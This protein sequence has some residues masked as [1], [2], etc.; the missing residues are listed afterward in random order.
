MNSTSA[1]DQSRLRVLAACEQ[2]SCVKQISERV[3]L[4]KAAVGACLKKLDGYVIKNAKVY[5][6]Q[7]KK[8]PKRTYVPRPINLRERARIERREAKRELQGVILPNGPLSFAREYERYTPPRGREV[9]E[10]HGSWA[11]RK[12]SPHIGCGS[13]AHVEMMG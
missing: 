10:T 6:W 8:N 7:F 1:S 12:D 9:K 13:Q 4:S 2:W 11:G 3:G 5:P